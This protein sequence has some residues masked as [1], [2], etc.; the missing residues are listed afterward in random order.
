MN[1]ARLSSV[2]LATAIMFAAQP[3]LAQPEDKAEA[4]YLRALLRTD[5]MAID[6]PEDKKSGLSS[7]NASEG[8][9]LITALNNC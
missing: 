9:A 4:N 5:P 6:I 3:L 2:F 1:A 8:K 7:C